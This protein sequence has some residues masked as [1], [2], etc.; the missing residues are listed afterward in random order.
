MYNTNEL[1]YI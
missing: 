1:P